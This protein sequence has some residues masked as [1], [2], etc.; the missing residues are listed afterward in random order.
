MFRNLTS[1]RECSLLSKVENRIKEKK[2]A[3]RRLQQKLND[4]RQRK[5]TSDFKSRGNDSKKR[6]RGAIQRS[7]K[8]QKNESIH[9]EENKDQKQVSSGVKAGNN[10]SSKYVANSCQ[11]DSANIVERSHQEKAVGHSASHHPRPLQN[12]DCSS[13]PAK[14]TTRWFDS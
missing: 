4:T 6:S 1:K 12:D 8:K 14:L 7:K 2:Q 5:D 3:E 10:A 13:G 9:V 11:V